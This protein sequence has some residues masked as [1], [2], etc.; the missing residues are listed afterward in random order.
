[1]DQYKVAIELGRN[2]EVFRAMLHGLEKAQ[3]V[4]RPAPDKWNLLEIVCHLHDEEREDF[5]ARVEHTLLHPELP[6]PPIDP[7][8][9][10]ESRKYRL[11]DFDRVLHLFLIERGRSVDY[12]NQLV[13]PQWDK[14]HMHPK[15]GAM[16]ASMLL[17]N[18][19]AHDYLHIRQI[20]ALKY[21]YLQAH[22]ADKLDYAGGW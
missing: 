12:L 4:W 3:Y 16:P 2:K 20:N 6:M 21:M 1:M 19:L 17:M 15:L 18:W 8:G 10:V 9:W 7:A 22:S 13:A 14:V 5:R 11:Q